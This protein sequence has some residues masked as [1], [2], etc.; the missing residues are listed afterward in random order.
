MPSTLAASGL[1]GKT[2]PPNGL[3]IRFQRI[4]RP[5]LPSLVGRAHHRHGLRLEQ[6]SQR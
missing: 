2:V 6:R 5:T 4:V 1:T 3:L